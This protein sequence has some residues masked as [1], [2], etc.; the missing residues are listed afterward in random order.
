VPGGCAFRTRCP[1]A[2]PLCAAEAPPLAA[3]ADGYRVACHVATGRIAR[4]AH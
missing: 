3:L 1:W 2:Q 4:P